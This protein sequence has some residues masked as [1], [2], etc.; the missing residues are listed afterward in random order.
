MKFYFTQYAKTIIPDY[1]Q[2]VTKL[3]LRYALNLII[4]NSIYNIKN[5]YFKFKIKLNKYNKF[6]YQKHLQLCVFPEK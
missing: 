3:P 4:R 6:I 1:Y 2:N 5:F